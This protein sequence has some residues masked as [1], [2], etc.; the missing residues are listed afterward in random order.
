M[1]EIFTREEYPCNTWRLGKVLIICLC[2]EFS[3]CALMTLSLTPFQHRNFPNGR[4]TIKLYKFFKIRWIC[5]S[6]LKHLMASQASTNFKSFYLSNKAKAVYL[7]VFFPANK[8]SMLCLDR[9]PSSFRLDREAGGFW[10]IY[11]VGSSGS[12]ATCKGDLG[13]TRCH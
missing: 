5:L 2:K 3:F 11:A 13:S 12:V 6:H 4:H 10:V 1:V 8:M 7:K 9:G